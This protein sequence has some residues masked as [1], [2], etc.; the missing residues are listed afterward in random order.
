MWLYPLTLICV[1]AGC[2]SKTTGSMLEELRFL[3]I[4]LV[5]KRNGLPCKGVISSMREFKEKTR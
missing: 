5:Q 4:R 3:I 1:S 2:G